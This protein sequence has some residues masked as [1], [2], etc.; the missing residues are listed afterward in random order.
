MTSENNSVAAVSGE[1]VLFLTL[2][3]IILL[4]IVFE[5]RQNTMVVQLWNRYKYSWAA[6]IWVYSKS[7]SL[8][9]WMWRQFF[10]TSVWAVFYPWGHVWR[11][12]CP[13]HR[14]QH[15]LN[16]APMFPEPN[17]IF[18]WYNSHWHKLGISSAVPTAALDIPQ[19]NFE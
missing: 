7:R 2:T 19:D 16:T 10:C 6:S 1:Y 15:H 4:Q 8:E 11:L 3:K 18:V 17:C 13:D 12:H 5:N 14:V 9:K